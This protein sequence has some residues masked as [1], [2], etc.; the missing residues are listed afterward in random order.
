VR[1][2][3][4]VVLAAQSSDHG[5]PANLEALAALSERRCPDFAAVDA[6]NPPDL[7]RHRAG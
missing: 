5:E 6:A 2:S 4:R 1:Q 3:G 7:E